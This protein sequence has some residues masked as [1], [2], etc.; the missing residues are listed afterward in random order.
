ME[1]IRM[2]QIETFTTPKGVQGR[3]LVDRDGLVVMNLLLKPGEKVPSH[4]TPVNV[5]FHVVKG[6]GIIEVGEEK[7]KVQEKDLVYSPQNIPHA[8]EASK[9]REFHVLVIKLPG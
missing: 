5:L 4:K 1:I 8:L 9:D 6:E 3:K 2:S 7:G